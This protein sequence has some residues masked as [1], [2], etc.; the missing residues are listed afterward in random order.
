MKSRVQSTT[1]VRSSYDPQLISELS[2]L[3]RNGTA[4][5]QHKQRTEAEAKWS[6][7]RHY[8]ILAFVGLSVL[9]WG[10]S[11]VCFSDGI[12]S[13]FGVG[14]FFFALL[15]GVL[16]MNGKHREAYVERQMANG[17]SRQEAEREYMKRYDGS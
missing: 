16:A 8:P 6:T 15:G 2:A 3:A 11:A 7:V 9:M 17:L 5:D 13:Y 14:I 10:V 4:N 12:A 1:N